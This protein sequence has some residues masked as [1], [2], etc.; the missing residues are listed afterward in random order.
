MVRGT[1]PTL[2]FILPKSLTDIKIKEVYVTMAQARRVILDKD[3]S[4][5]KIQ[6]NNIFL[7]L[8]QEDT[9]KFKH[10]IKIEIQVA[11][12]TDRNLVYR[13]KMLYIDAKRILKEGII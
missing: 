13:S 5:V 4:C 9:L 11:I 2:K 12:K 10:D 8:T 1:T 6:D 3:I 7:S